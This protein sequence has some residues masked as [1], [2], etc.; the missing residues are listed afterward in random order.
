MTMH[1]SSHIEIAVQ[2]EQ[3]LL[4]AV[5][6]RRDIAAA[7]SMFQRDGATVDGI[8]AHV[9]SDLGVEDQQVIEN[10]RVA[11]PEVQGG[12]AVQDVSTIAHVFPEIPDERAVGTGSA[13]QRPLR[14]AV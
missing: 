1:G 5:W 14:N 4:A 10:E 11:V 8:C 12:S 2:P 13:G 7:C 3:V 9:T 6:R